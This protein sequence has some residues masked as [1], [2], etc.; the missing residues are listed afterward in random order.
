MWLAKHKFC[1]EL[2]IDYGHEQRSEY[3]YFYDENVAWEYAAKIMKQGFTTIKQEIK[4]YELEYHE[5]FL[6]EEDELY[7]TIYGTRNIY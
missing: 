4:V 2:I 7:E 3:E 1:V 6:D 5:I